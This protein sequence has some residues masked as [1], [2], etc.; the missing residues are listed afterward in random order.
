LHSVVFAAALLA[1]SGHADCA[2]E[3][4]H[5]E[6]KRTFRQP[7]CPSRIYESTPLDGE[8]SGRIEI[9]QCSDLV[10]AIV[11]VAAQEGSAA[12]TRFK[13]RIVELGYLA[14]KTS[15]TEFASFVSESTAKWAKVIRGR[16]H[17]G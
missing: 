3:C 13:A 17:Q 14:F 15:Q 10:C 5:S 16:E 11:G 2:D 7:H 1:Q 4:P 9:P 6:V 8:R 12:P